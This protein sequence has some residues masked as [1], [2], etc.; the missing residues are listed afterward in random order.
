[1]T[2]SPSVTVQDPFSGRS[3]K[4]PSHDKSRA[5]GRQL[6]AR[7]LPRLRDSPT[8]GTTHAPLAVYARTLELPLDNAAFLLA[9][10]LG[11]I[12][13]GHVRWRHFRT[14]VAILRFGEAVIACIPGEIYPELVNGGVE[15]AP[16]GDFDL[17]PVEVP[18]IRELLP[19]RVK[20]VFGL[21]NDEIGYIIPKSEWDR[22]PPFLY[23]ATKPVYGEVNSPGPD[24][25][26]RLHAA[27]RE[28][29]QRLA[30]DGR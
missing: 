7:I 26:P 21:A 17:E 29:S 11:L 28:L 20:F 8:A 4:L 10:V 12:D 19:G 14:E 27:L 6:A 1:M 22:K 16:G 18:P 24:T 5:V 3:F 23:G 9:P 30:A 25:A 2:T 13:R 15:R